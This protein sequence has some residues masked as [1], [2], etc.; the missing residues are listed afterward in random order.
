MILYLI[1]HMYQ[2]GICQEPQ[3]LCEALSQ[4]QVQ[5]LTQVELVATIPQTCHL[6]SHQWNILMILDLNH[7]MYQ[8][9]VHTYQAYNLQ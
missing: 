2:V 7:H 6:Q 4:T 5:L 9:G 8:M 3:L 1:H